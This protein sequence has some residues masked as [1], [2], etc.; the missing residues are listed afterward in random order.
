M[1][2]LH[3]LEGD[4]SKT[5]VILFHFFKSQ[6]NMGVFSFLPLIFVSFISRL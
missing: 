6:L 3:R 4:S 2:S 1:V 5:S